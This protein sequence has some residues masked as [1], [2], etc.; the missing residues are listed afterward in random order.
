LNDKT[1]IRVRG[2]CFLKSILLGAL[3]LI[4]AM[5]IGLVVE[6]F[7]PSAQALNRYESLITCTLVLKDGRFAA[8]KP[9][10]ARSD[11]GS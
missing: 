6:A 11:E 9:C 10:A 3:A 5:A 4:I 1:C 8:A 7:T 2:T